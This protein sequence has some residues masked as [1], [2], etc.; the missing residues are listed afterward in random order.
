M[1]A[2]PSNPRYHVE[3]PTHTLTFWLFQPQVTGLQQAHPAA[4]HPRNF[5]P[6]FRRWFHA[7]HSLFFLVVLFLSSLFLMFRYIIPDKSGSHRSFLILS[8][9]FF[10]GK[11][12]GSFGR[13]GRCSGERVDSLQWR[14][15]DRR[16]E[17][18]QSGRARKT[19]QNAWNRIGH[20]QR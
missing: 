16:R 9:L 18:K 12:N 17:F 1:C 6:P 8:S 13:L 4:T 11:S 19:V 5:R 14:I 20:C 15:A 7:N 10:S 3:S 2:P